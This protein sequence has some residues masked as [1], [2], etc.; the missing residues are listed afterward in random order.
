MPVWR[1]CLA[2]RHHRKQTENEGRGFFCLYFHLYVNPSLDLGC[3]LRDS[4]VRLVNAFTQTNSEGGGKLMRPRS[5]EA[6]DHFQGVAV[7]RAVSTPEPLQFLPGSLLKHTLDC[8][9]FLN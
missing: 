6:I 8:L 3:G 2:A 7:C 1:R 5:P 4:S 9:I